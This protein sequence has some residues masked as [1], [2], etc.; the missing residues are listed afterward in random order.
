MLNT[1]VGEDLR[2]KTD[3]PRSPHSPFTGNRDDR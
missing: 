2:I 3:R 1:L